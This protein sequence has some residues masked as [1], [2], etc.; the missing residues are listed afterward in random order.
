MALIGLLAFKALKHWVAATTR[1]D[2]SNKRAGLA[3]GR[4]PGA[5]SVSGNLSDLLKGGLGGSS[6]EA[7]PEAC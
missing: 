7:R 5:T 2:R 6:E 1:N 4:N 3:S